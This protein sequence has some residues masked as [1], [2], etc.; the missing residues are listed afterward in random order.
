M[1]PHKREYYELVAEAALLSRKST[2]SLSVLSET[3]S[4]TVNSTLNSRETSLAR[5]MISIDDTPAFTRLTFRSLGMS[6]AWPSTSMFLFTRLISRVS[7]SPIDNDLPGG[8]AIGW[9]DRSRVA[10]LC[11][12][13]GR[14]C[15]I[16][17]EI[18]RRLRVSGVHGATYR[19][20]RAAWGEPART[21]CVGH[22]AGRAFGAF[23]VVY[24]GPVPGTGTGITEG[25]GWWRRGGLAVSPTYRGRVRVVGGRSWWGWVGAVGVGVGIGGRSA[26]LG[27]GWLRG[28]ATSRGW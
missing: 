24:R 15:P 28:G 10:Y 21:T 19:P 3:H 16:C 12:R 22:A 18:G 9:D 25:L 5:A 8:F 26:C 1:T 4:S 17:G 13:A 27:G 20:D 7:V 23:G 11:Q 14:F 2:T 6:R